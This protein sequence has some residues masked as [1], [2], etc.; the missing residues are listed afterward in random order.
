MRIVK[1]SVVV[2]GPIDGTRILR[3]IEWVAR[4]CYKSEGLICDGS[5]ERLVRKLLDHDPPHLAM[6]DHATIRAVFTV[7]RGVTHEIVRHRI[8]VAFA[9]ES[10]RYCNYSKGKFGG[11]IS[12]IEPPGLSESSRPEWQCAV[13]AAEQAYLTLLAQGAAPQIAR[14]VL[15]T[16][17]K[18]EIV[19]TANVTAWRHIFRQRTDHAAHPQMR[20]VMAP[21]LAWLRARV[22]VVFDGV[23]STDLPAG[24]E[25]AEIREEVR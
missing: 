14:S 7:D 20:Q 4:H 13:R 5:A 3:D 15:P 1:P 17:T 23:G 21:L 8:G 12:V 10:T 9:Q 22:P 25:P 18:A 2:D 11:E 16:C 6:A 19:V 24:V